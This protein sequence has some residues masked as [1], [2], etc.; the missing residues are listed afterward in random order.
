VIAVSEAQVI[1]GAGPALREG[2][3]C[4]DG[5]GRLNRGDCAFEIV[6]P[7]L[8][9]IALPDQRDVIL[10]KALGKDGLQF[11]PFGRILI[12]CDQGQS[13]PTQLGALV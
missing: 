11:R 13:L 5:E 4:I 1:L 9:G 3:A 2:L 8:Q 7:V 10:Q 12:A 6:R